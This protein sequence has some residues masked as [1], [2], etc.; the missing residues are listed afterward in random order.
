MDE[1]DNDELL[2]KAKSV[3]TQAYNSQSPASTQITENEMF[4]IWF[5][6]TLRNWKAVVSTSEHPGLL[7]EV[8]YNG[9]KRETYADTYFKMNNVVIPDNN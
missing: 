4:I 2:K 1:H 8:T 3:A 7:I 5:S 6:K 9:D